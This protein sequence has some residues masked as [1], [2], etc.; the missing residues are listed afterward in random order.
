MIVVNV[1]IVIVRSGFLDFFPEPFLLTPSLH[2]VR[3]QELEPLVVHGGPEPDGLRQGHAAL[4]GAGGHARH[5]GAAVGGQVGGG[6]KILV[7]FTL[8]NN[9]M[10][11]TSI[12]YTCAKFHFF[13]STYSN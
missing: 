12:N 4:G 1:T 11:K 9:S 6:G 3:P 7:Y 10:S 5:H 13:N 8:E 2:P